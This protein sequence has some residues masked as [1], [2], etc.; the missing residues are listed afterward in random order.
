M[1]VSP[2]GSAS[3]PS[4]LARAGAPGTASPAGRARAL[5][6]RSYGFRWLWI[7][8]VAVPLLAFA[9]AAEFS[10]RQIQVE[11]RARLT[12][13]VDMLHEHA[14]RSFEMQEAILTAADERVA[15]MSWDEISNSREV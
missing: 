13:T 9:G 3:S 1:S 14:L 10:W 15:G 7:T 4:I 12:R 5:W 6:G 8:S 2:Q 11:A